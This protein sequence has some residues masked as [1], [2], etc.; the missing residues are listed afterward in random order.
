MTSSAR[1]VRYGRRGG[2]WADASAG[3]VAAALAEI[4]EART[5]ARRLDRSD[6]LADGAKRWPDPHTH[7]SRP[8]GDDE[9]EGRARMAAA[10]ESA[11]LDLNDIDRQALV[12]FPNPRSGV[13][14]RRD[15][16]AVS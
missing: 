9:W 7:I 6:P 16:G 11:G 4:D 10:R 15:I 14:G 1:D 13:T 5:R 2:R 12:R 8:V 3:K